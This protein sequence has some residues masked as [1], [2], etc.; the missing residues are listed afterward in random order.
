MN[1]IKEILI[2]KINN[3]DWWHVTPRDPDA[4][5][6]RGKFL[7]S[8]FLRAEFYGRPND[9][10]EKVKIQNP[11][12]GFSEIE[13]LKQLFGKLLGK[14]MMQT[15]LDEDSY[16]SRIDFDAQMYRRAK[17]LGYDAIVLMAPSGKV[18]L[19]RGRKPNA[20]ELNIFNI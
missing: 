12:F 1:N 19:Q 17:E 3:S 8:T 11:V 2:H 7:A 6:K 15:I 14:S 20:I 5:Q 4:Y 9:Q 10:A 13:I 16:E 18:A